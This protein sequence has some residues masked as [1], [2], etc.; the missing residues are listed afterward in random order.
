MTFIKLFVTA[1]I[2]FLAIDF[3]WLGLIAKNV[4]SQELG[5]LMKPEVNF[6]AAFLFYAIFIVALTVFVIMPGIEAGSI[7]KVMLL[8][9]LFGLASYAT[10]D[11]TNY[12]TLANFPLKIVLIDLAWGT[13]LGTSTSTLTYIIYQ[14]VLK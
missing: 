3:L 9:A 4:Y 14:G 12:A 11:L 7:W 13:F 6:Y 5:S 1:F 10:Y 2:I 8:G